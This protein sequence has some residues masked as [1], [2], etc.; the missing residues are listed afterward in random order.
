MARIIFIRFLGIVFFA[1][2][3]ISCQADESKTTP[4]NSLGDI[5][6]E[7]MNVVPTKFPDQPSLVHAPLETAQQIEISRYPSGS[8]V[9]IFL[10]GPDSKGLDPESNPFALQV[11]VIVRNPDGDLITIPAFYDGDGHGGLDGDLWVARLF[12]YKT[13]IWHYKI[14][15]EEISLDGSVGSFEVVLNPECSLEQV[16]DNLN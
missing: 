16:G 5:H 11:D 4:G 13:G 14:V 7:R 15:S 2:I 9:E 6:T 1:V 10:N 3:L 12:P 8:K